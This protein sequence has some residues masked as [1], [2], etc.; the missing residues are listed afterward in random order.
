MVNMGIKQWSTTSNSRMLLKLN[1][2]L[3]DKSAQYPLE[4][5]P[6]WMIQQHTIYVQCQQTMPMQE[7]S[8]CSGV[9]R[10]G[11]DGG[12]LSNTLCPNVVLEVDFVSVTNLQIILINAC[13]I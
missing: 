4:L 8:L 2:M 6:C 1:H 11:Q 10:P 5:C 7:V 3:S 13:D 9:E 12:S